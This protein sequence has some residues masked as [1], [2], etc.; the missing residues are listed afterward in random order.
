MTLPESKI[1]HKYL[2]GLFGVEIGGSLYNP[3]GLNTLNVDFSIENSFRKEEKRLC[4]KSM[5]VDLIADASNLPLKFNSIDFIVSSHVIEHLPHPKDVL[6]DWYKIV[7]QYIFIICPH[8]QR[9][10]DSNRRLSLLNEVLV[11]TDSKS[12]A[13][14]FVWNT[15]LLLK[16]CT[17]LMLPV[18]ACHD[19]DDKALNGFTI[20]IQKEGT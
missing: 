4:G 15:E 12:K 3:F 18:V 6:L 17:Y 9:T 5:P 8:Y 13:H 1:A 19:V 14:H 2:D 16:L 7:K 10:F 20:I 11:G